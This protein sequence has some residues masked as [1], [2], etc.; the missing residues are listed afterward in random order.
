LI[1][2]DATSGTVTTVTR[3]SERTVSRATVRAVAACGVLGALAVGITLAL[4]GSNVGYGVDSSVYLGVAHN[5]VTG[6]GPTVPMTFYTDHYTP[7]RAFDF[8]GAV[9]ST[10]FPPLYSTVLAGFEALGLTAT[11]AARATV[12]LLHAVDAVLVAV[13]LSRV[14]TRRRW[15]SAFAGTALL[16]TVDTWLVTHSFAMS[17]PLL[18]TVVLAWILVVARHLS[19]GS[20]TTLAW[21]A[22]LAAAAVLTRWVGISVGAAGAVLVL[23]RR[24]WLRRVR[25]TRAAIV[26]GAAVGA[27]GAWSLYGRIAGGSEPRLLAV[28]APRD[29]FGSLLQVVTGWFAP[30][31][32]AG[33]VLGAALVIATVATVATVTRAPVGAGGASTERSE[34]VW[35]LTAGA[36]FAV[37]YV[38]V[39]YV[40]R[41]FLDISIPTDGAKGIL[42]AFE[43]PRIYVPLL[44]VVLVAV[45]AGIDRTAVT[46]AAGA[47]AGGYAVLVACILF[48]VLPP[49][50]LD[51][52]YDRTAML[53]GGVSSRP[54]PA[55]LAVRAVPRDA[56]IVTNVPSM[57]YGRTGRACLMVPLHRIAVTGRVNT[58]FAREV[59]Q[60][61]VLLVQHRGLLVI[62]ANGFGASTAAGASDFARWSRLVP[63]AQA[64]GVSVYRVDA[65]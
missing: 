24:G 64:A 29:F 21:V 50:H 3:P 52:A 10:H 15:L 4:T 36:V 55:L 23:G 37:T 63:L 6:R 43:A 13:I 5:L 30:T 35:I 44:P 1:R 41:T 48:A 49:S 65:A 34:R 51:D 42:A 31:V 12:A 59:E 56:P 11:G 39:V 57:V 54:S 58:A 60:T 26:L 9:P 62:A 33:T 40:S 7:L 53:I 14:L 46:L 2:D 32:W 27:G 47:K 18:M 16:F 38:I 45:L 8:H 28:H 19:S 61:A 20:R 17:E 25:V 22:A